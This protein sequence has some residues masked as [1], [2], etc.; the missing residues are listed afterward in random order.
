MTTKFI[1]C[2]L[3]QIT[4]DLL[5]AEHVLQQSPLYWVFHPSSSVKDEG[6]LPLF[7]WVDSEWT[8]DIE[9]AD[10]MSYKRVLWKALLLRT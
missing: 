10:L 7:E 9:D 5:L 6:Y 1:L 8:F 3:M 2:H 4:H